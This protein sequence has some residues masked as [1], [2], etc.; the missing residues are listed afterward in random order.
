MADDVT[1]PSNPPIVLVVLVEEEKFEETSFNVNVSQRLHEE[2]SSRRLV[3]TQINHSAWDCPF[4]P[5]S[6]ALAIYLEFFLIHGVAPKRFEKCQWENDDVHLDY[7]TWIPDDGHYHWLQSPI[8]PL[9][10]EH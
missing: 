10:M 8:N 6:H 1:T 7:R 3:H 5:N 4:P 9:S 2:K